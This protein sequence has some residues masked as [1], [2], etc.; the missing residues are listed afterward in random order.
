MS[1]KKPNQT[2]GGGAGVAAAECGSVLLQ[3]ASAE[4]TSKGGVGA[5]KNAIVVEGRDGGEAAVSVSHP[6]PLLSS[7][8]C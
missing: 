7:S 6:A 3:G 2:T 8:L 4:G 5:A 1:D